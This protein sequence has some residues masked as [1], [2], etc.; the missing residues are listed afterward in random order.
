MICRESSKPPYTSL[1]NEENTTKLLKE[2]FAEVVAEN[3][4]TLRALTL[5]HEQL[6]SAFEAEENRVTSAE[7]ELK[8]VMQTKTQSEQELTLIITRLNETQQ[9]Q[10]ADLTR[11]EG[12]VGRQNPASV[13]LQKI[14]W[15][16]S[17]RIRNNWNHHFDLP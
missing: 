6:K 15:D 3:E 5:E 10:V 17:S 13:S 16:H 7:K 11:S 8:T 14:S 12:C 9:Q 4:K 1:Q 2:N